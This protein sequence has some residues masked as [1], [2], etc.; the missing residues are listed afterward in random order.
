MGTAAPPAEELPAAEAGS[1]AS[2]DKDQP[3][4]S[5]KLAWYATVL[6]TLATMMNFFDI[7]IFGL[8][9]ETIKH[10]LALTD[11]QVGLLLGPAGILFYVF[12][13]IPLARLVDIY[14]RTTILG[15]GLVITSGMTAVTGLIQTYGQLFFT[16]MCVG[17]GGSAHAPGTYSL[18]AD[19][20]PPQKLPRAF[21]FLQLGFI[22]GSGLGVIIGGVLLS[23]V[24][25]WAPT[26]VGPFSIRNWQWV[27]IWIATPGLFIAF[28]IFLL[29]EPPRRGK[30]A[31]GKVL[32]MRAVFREIWNRR[33]VYFP[34]FIGLALSAIEAQGL[35]AWRF[36]FMIRTY[37]WTPEQIAWWSGPILIAAML[38][39]AALGTWMTERLGKRYRDAPIRT[40]AI[41][42]ALCIPFSVASPL[43]STGELSIILG[44]LS[45][46]FGIAAGV[47]QNVAI[48]TI[49]PNEMRGQ[50]TAIYLF[51]FI[52]VGSLG[53]LLVSL[54]TTYIAGGEANLWISMTIVPAVFLPL[55]V[56]AIARGMKPYAQEIERMEAGRV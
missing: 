7:G 6:F 35:I 25:G 48:Q 15:I 12:V 3:W 27:L 26:E 21:G 33:R 11:V 34:L 47:P 29:P 51:M 9:I 24:M 2:I 55:A 4:P 53:S 50:V 31:T 30:I 23:H 10:D 43:M 5:R 45:G 28:L 16:R 36:P 18:L 20:F 49:T 1:P 42:F 17:V 32:P 13:G 41:V 46:V 52:A 8:M 38:I 44:T 40:T 56:Y 39:G 19:Y 22:L 14:R 54:V 37:G